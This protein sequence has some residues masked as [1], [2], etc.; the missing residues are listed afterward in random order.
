M[1]RR[2]ANTSM[3]SV[4]LETHSASAAGPVISRSSRR[5]SVSNETPIRGRL[6]GS[7]VEVHEAEATPAFD[8]PAAG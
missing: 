4:V 2:V 6:P 7:T 1:L 8:M 3:S 5:A